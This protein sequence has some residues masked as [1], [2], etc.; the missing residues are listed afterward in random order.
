[1]AP[2][3]GNRARG[4]AKN[5]PVVRFKSPF[6]RQLK[7]LGT[8]PLVTL[9]NRAHVDA[10]QYKDLSLA[11]QALLKKYPADTHF[12]IGLGRDPAPIMAFLQNLGGKELAVNFPASSNDSNNATVEVLAK[13]VEKLIPPEVLASG[14]TIVFLDATTSGRGLDFYVPKIVP[15]L[16]GAKVIKAAYGI[17]HD[18]KR[19]KWRIYSN[20]GDKQVIDTAPFP[21]VNKFFTE[22]YEDVVSEFPRHGPGKDPIAVLDSPLPQYKQYRDALMQ[23]MQRDG[24]LHKFLTSKG[25]PAFRKGLAAETSKPEID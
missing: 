17:Q 11:T 7:P 13:Y 21:E 19:E 24:E 14:R 8:G 12:F 1:M 3:A 10:R 18:G 5:A 22:P 20:P 15:S 25:G 2:R 9:E 16:G 23:R 4:R 6:R